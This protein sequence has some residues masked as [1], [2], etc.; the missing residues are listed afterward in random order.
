LQSGLFPPQKHVS[1]LWNDELVLKHYFV[2][3]I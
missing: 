3:K 1:N 2:N